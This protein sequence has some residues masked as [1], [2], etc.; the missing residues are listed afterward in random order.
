MNKPILDIKSVT[1][2]AVTR[3]A[4]PGSRKV[5][6]DGVPFREIAALIGRRL[7]LPVVDKSRKEASK[8]FSWFLMFAG[9]DAPASSARTR[10]D[11]GWEPTQ[12]GLLADIDQ[13]GYCKV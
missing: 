13:P 11:L 12:P 4:L 1:N 8:Q 10:A 2:D 7:N 5:Y 6:V 3:G 9:V